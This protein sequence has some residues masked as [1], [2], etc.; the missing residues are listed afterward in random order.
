MRI[1]ICE[2]SYIW[3]NI[4]KL[5]IQKLLYISNQLMKNYVKFFIKSWF[6]VFI[7]NIQQ[8]VTTYEYNQSN[9]QQQFWLKKISQ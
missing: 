1:Y 3:L 4:T 6:Y 2:Y 5:S 7:K 9:G 8:K